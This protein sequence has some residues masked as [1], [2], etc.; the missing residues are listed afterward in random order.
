[1][2]G[3]FWLVVLGGMVAPPVAFSRHLKQGPPTSLEAP[4]WISDNFHSVGEGTPDKWHVCGNKVSN[5]EIINDL[6]NVLNI[7]M[8]R[9]GIAKL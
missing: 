1:M 6:I 5:I 4:V 9:Y 2:P 8:R 3:H 7:I